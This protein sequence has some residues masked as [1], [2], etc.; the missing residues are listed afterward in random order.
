MKRKNEGVRGLTGAFKDCCQ[1]A[2]ENH[3]LGKYIRIVGSMRVHLNLSE[4]SLQS[5]M[6]FSS[7]VQLN[8]NRQSGQ[9]IE[10]S[11]VCGFPR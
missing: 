2:R 10:L 5:C 7:S 11:R 8:G 4:I 1:T 6:I 9:S 3:G